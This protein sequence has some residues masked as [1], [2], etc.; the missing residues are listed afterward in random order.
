MK[1]TK[2][3]FKITVILVYIVFFVISNALQ[4]KDLI[5]VLPVIEDKY[6]ENNLNSINLEGYLGQKLN[7][8]ISQRIKKQDVNELIEPFKFIFY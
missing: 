8:C 7:L 5:K 4:A 2:S 3:K 1:S 6:I